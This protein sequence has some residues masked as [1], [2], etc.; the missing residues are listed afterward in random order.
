MVESALAPPL[1]DDEAPR[2]L[3][4]IRRLHALMEGL[5]YKAK[6][7]TG[8]GFHRCS[9]EYTALEIEIRGLADRYREWEARQPPR[10]KCRM[11]KAWLRP[12]D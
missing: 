10:E 7:S 9:T 11:A 2:V 12:Q 4:E 6:P 1:T 8:L 3:A 5:P